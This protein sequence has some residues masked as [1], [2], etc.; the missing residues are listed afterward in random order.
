MLAA[1]YA[2]VGVEASL[3][4]R[5]AYKGITHPLIANLV[6]LLCCT[7]G[8]VPNPNPSPSQSPSPTPTPSPYP[9]PKP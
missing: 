6:G 7:Q 5:R 8:E 2:R 9:Y 1:L 4:L 3:D